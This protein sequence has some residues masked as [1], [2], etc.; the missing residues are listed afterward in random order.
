MN[1]DEKISFKELIECGQLLP[2]EP[3]R[4]LQIFKDKPVRRD[5]TILLLS[6]IAVLSICICLHYSLNAMQ[7]VEPEISVS[8]I[9]IESHQSSVSSQYKNGKVNINTAGI[10]ALC[11]IKYIGESKALSIVS[12]REAN[13]PFKSISDIKNVSGIGD[14]TFEKIKENICV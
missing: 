11:T 6:I 5:Y 1:S 8:G 2:E 3:Q 9:S 14:A 4:D 12:Y 7:K 13:G 10:E